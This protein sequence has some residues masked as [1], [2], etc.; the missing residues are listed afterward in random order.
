MATVTVT[1]PPSARNRHSWRSFVNFIG[2]RGKA[3]SLD[4]ATGELTLF[5]GDQATIDAQLVTYVAD[6]TNIDDDFQD[7]LDDEAKDSAKS[8]F[9][10][11]SILTALIKE[12]VDQLNDIRAQTGQPAL[13]FGQVNADIRNRIGQ[14]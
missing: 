7:V 8:E 10:D 6:Q 5:E 1:L 4:Q 3:S 14:P 13:N 2:Q 12:M 9:D 11:D